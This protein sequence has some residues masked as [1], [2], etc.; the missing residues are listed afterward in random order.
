MPEDTN[1]SLHERILASA[2]T[3][4]AKNGY[5][6]A[7]LRQITQAANANL[8]A[9]NYHFGD[10][11]TLF[12]EVLVRRLRPINESRL[13]RLQEAERIAGVA[14]VPLALVIELLVQPLFELGR[15]H[16]AHALRVIGRCPT[17]PQPFITDLLSR[18]FHPVMARFGQAVR[19]HV[20]AL[21]P[22][23][24]LWRLS[25]VVGA[26]H[27][28]FATMHGMKDLT[29]GICRSDDYEGAQRRFIRFAVAAFTAPA[30]PESK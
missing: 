25:F 8:A 9:V 28:T 30:A 17:E 12:G 4:F 13:A 3:L 24:F 1:I 2:E 18:E 10:K 14:P 7:S 29:R 21:T 16:G 15:G 20:P 27:H 5:D 11:E 19:R 22:E 23:D 6:G 26:L